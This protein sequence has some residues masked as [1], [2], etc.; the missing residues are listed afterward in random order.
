MFLPLAKLQ[1]LA[2]HHTW[3]DDRNLIDSVSIERKK[4]KKEELLCLSLY[5]F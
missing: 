3:D 2:T 1:N 4:E 5:L